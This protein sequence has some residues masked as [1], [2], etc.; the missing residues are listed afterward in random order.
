MLEAEAREKSCCNDTIVTC[1][2][3][4]C[5]AWRFNP[6]WADSAFANAIIKAAKD[7]GD[8]ASNKMKATAH[9]MANR[10]L[11]G[12]PTKPFDGYCGLAGAVAYKEIFKET[13]D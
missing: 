13:N 5:M 3:S 2:A 10:A 12:L 1:I 8:T 11:Y 7:I 9:V 4:K 6:L